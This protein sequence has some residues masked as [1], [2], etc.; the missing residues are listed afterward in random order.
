[1]HTSAGCFYHVWWVI[2]VLLSHTKFNCVATS[3]LPSSIQACLRPWRLFF[4]ALGKLLLSPFER[5]IISQSWQH[6]A[7][8]CIS[9]LFVRSRNFFVLAGIP[10]CRNMSLTQLNQKKKS[11]EYLTNSPRGTIRTL[12]WMHTYIHTYIHTYDWGMESFRYVSQKAIFPH[13][14]DLTSYTHRAMGFW[15]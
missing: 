7:R 12:E 13:T 15:R 5:F 6:T 9:L 3:G 4:C 2:L 10:N 14:S 11:H 8:R 1:M